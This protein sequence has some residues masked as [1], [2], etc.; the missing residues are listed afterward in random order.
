MQRDRY[1][2]KNAALFALGNI[3]TKLIS[4]FL[5]PL[6]T[7]VL[8]TAEYGVV[9]LVAS[10]CT[11][12]VPILTL[13][14]GEAVMRFSLDKDADYNK[15]MSVGIL[16]MIFSVIIGVII[17]PVSSLF[18]STR[19]YSVF[20]F[21][22]SITSGVNQILICN[23]RGREKLLEYAISNILHTLCIAALN[24]LFLVYFKL[25]VV[26]YF[27][28][29][30]LSNVVTGIYA[31]VCGKVCQGIFKIEIDVK[32][33][34]TMLAYS[35]VLIPNSFMWW[36]MNSSDRL[37]VTAMVGSA[38]NGIYAVSYKVPTL[39]STLS[40][41]FN[42]AWSYS[43]IKENESADKEEYNNQMYDQMAK[44][45]ICITGSL[46]VILKPFMNIYVDKNYYEAWK[47]TPYLLVGFMFMTLGTF[48]S[49]SYTVN[50][51]SKGFL[52]SGS[53]GA[54]INIVLNFILIPKMKVAGAAF[55][56]GISYLAV[57]IFRAFHTRKY[58]VINVWKKKH[59]IGYLIVFVMAATLF[60]DTW[61][62]Q[63]ILCIEYVVLIWLMRD[64]IHAILKMMLR[65]VK[66]IKK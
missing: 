11:V 50:K 35:I 19:E 54:I 59:L 20:I 60:I 17:L 47:Y 27:C 12:L 14:I 55:A 32:L 49:T 46:L 31:F 33:I 58:L 5:V 4:F 23:L 52:I 2:A 36:I 64:Y 57:Y 65:I 22:Y 28:A 24:I 38:A 53:F 25:G 66:K 61:I 51:D 8:S 30:I 39:L 3:G 41:I 7:G 48:L 45:V 26:G 21:L 63:I 42:Q 13:N 29:Y 9:D 62:G 34:R 15:I 43:A 40:V 37:M 6:Y 16:F 56:T 18:D 10:I 44:T 1:L